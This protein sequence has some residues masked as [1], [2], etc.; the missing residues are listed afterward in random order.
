MPGLDPMADAS[1]R[2]SARKA[3]FL[4][5]QALVAAEGI[6]FVAAGALQFVAAAGGDPTPLFVSTVLL[7]LA[8][9]LLYMAVALRGRGSTPFFTT[10]VASFFGLLILASLGGGEAARLAG[11]GLAVLV[12]GALVLLRNRFHLRP[13][14]IVKEEKLPPEV[15]GTIATKV[16]GVQ[17]RECRDDDVW[18]TNDKRLVCKNCGSTDA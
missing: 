10:L 16:R 17:C 11:V 8:A 7:L 15:A 14:E 12:I 18:I 3:S 5:L 1:R 2:P 4:V 9:T 6:A 13:G